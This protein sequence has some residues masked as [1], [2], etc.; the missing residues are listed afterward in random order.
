LH[1]G[2]VE[3]SSDGEGTVSTF[4][5]HLPLMI[6]HP[7]PAIDERRKRGRDRALAPAESGGHGLDGVHV[8]PGPSERSV[9]C[10]RFGPTF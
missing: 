3:A 7:Q 1:G 5:V 2:S 8:L 9:N 4:R 6:V 10:Q